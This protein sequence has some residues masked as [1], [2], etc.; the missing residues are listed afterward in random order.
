MSGPSRRPGSPQEDPR[1]GSAEISPLMIPMLFLGIV[2]GFLAG[3]FLLW[4]G[5]LVVAAVLGLAVTMVFS[6]R[7][8]DAATGAVLGV[9]LGYIGLILVAFFRG[10]V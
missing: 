8:R 9:L 5:L 3:Y 4:W 7:S 2:V 6:G 1:G 10:V